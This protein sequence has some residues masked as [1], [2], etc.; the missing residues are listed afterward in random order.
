MTDMTT[1]FRE[2]LNIN[3]LEAACGVAK[4]ARTLRQKKAI[5]NIKYCA[6]DQW[7]Y[8]NS[9]YDEKS[10]SAR[11]YM[12]DATDLF[13]TIYQESMRNVYDEGS[14]YFGTAAEEF[15]KDVRFCGTEFLKK[16]CL[17]YTAAL[18]EESVYEVEGT[19]EDCMRI[20]EDLKKIQSEISQ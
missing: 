13:K 20:I 16:V 6:N 8:V 1:N 14:V 15:M 4:G 7:G 11:N 9:W 2:I 19:E 5:R 18:L 10:E 17:Y 3:T 12:L